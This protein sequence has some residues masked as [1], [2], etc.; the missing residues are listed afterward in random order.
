MQKGPGENFAKYRWWPRNGCDCRS[1]ARILKTTNILAG[2]DSDFRQRGC[3]RIIHIQGSAQNFPSG[4]QVVMQC[5][6]LKI[7]CVFYY[8][9]S[10]VYY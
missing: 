4:R 2:A 6:Q 3:T 7:F 8:S 10:W 9:I 5:V 1:V